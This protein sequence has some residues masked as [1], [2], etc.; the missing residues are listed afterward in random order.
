MI[1]AIVLSILLGW[2]WTEITTEPVCQQEV[3]KS[4][5]KYTMPVNCS[6]ITGVEGE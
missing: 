2:G 6:V 1:E 5:V 3:I 4:G